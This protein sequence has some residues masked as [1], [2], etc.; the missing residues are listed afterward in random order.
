MRERAR[1]VAPAAHGR[2]CSV[3]R[4]AIA[5]STTQAQ[6]K[7]EHDAGQQS[8]GEQRRDRDAGHRADG[9]EHEARRNGFGHCAPV[10]EAARPVAGLGAAPL[11]FRKQH[12]RDRRHVGGLRAGNAGD[13]IHRRDQHDSTGRRAR[14]RAGSPGTPPWPARHAGHFDQQAEKD[15][16]RHGKQDDVRHAL[17]HAAD[18][19]VSGVV[20]RDA[21]DSRRSQAP[22]ANAIGT[23]AN[24]RGRDNADEEDQEIELPSLRNT[25][26]AVQNSAT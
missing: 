17:I 20:R 15:E 1:D 19:T 4:V 25:G 12:R 23:P 14:A 11:H 9:D 13:E 2:D 8:A 7:G 16:Q 18:H 5:P 10:A 3:C 6:Q 22:N 21:R 26:A 24:T